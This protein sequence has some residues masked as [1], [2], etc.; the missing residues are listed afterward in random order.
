MVVVGRTGLIQPLLFLGWTLNYEMFFYLLFALSLFLPNMPMRVAALS[1]GLVGL[2]ATGLVLKPQDVTADWIF[3][4]PM[5]A[6]FHR[7]S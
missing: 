4:V 5:R 1:A 2:V 7:Q 6:Y 3:S